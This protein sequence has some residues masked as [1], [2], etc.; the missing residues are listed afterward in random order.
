MLRR[1]GERSGLLYAMPSLAVLATAALVLGPGRERPAVGVRVWGVPAEGSKTAAWRLETIERQFGADQAIT[2]RGM[3]LSLVQGD[4]RLA[5]WSGASGDDGVAEALVRA[6]E[7]LS[8]SVEARIVQGRT[9]LAHGSIAL[10]RVPPPAL[11]RRLA[12][13]TSQGP[14]ALRVDIARGVL[15][16]PFPG[17]I[18]VLALRDGG[19]P[20]QGVA[21]S[22]TATGAEIDAASAKDLRTDAKG[23]ASIRLV[24]TWH[25][26]ELKI[27]A[28]DPRADPPAKSTW[29][30]GLPVHP[31]A[32]WLGLGRPR[33]EVVSPVPR[34]RAYVSALG[35]DGRVFGAVV[36]LAR[37]ETGLF[38]GAFDMAQLAGLG[39]EVLTIAG[40]SQEVG[41]GTASWPLESTQ[42][43][44]SAP[45]VEL[46]LDGVP[47]AERREKARAS[48]ARLAS[49]AVA[50]VAAAFE[51]VL[52]VLY[53]RASQTKLTAHLAALSE[54]PDDTA[55]AERMTAA[56]ASR[57]LTLVALVGVVVL[58]FGAVA[59]FAIVR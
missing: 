30:G 46:M 56:P 25:S 41:S 1:V 10:H 54:S 34:D 16:A 29:E 31:G 2:V 50:L 20:A 40:D 44:V 18:R 59:A 38:E 55:A 51:A 47:F 17:L 42:A 49:V 27:E 58:G 8:G 37:T 11:D 39:A 5:Q 52:L 6:E 43:V 33:V 23:E 19:V 57:A 15:G 24:P 21:V 53:S 12:E 48:N 9:Q 32:L 28:S 14:I 45:R 7:P 3:E 22:A 13:G 4:R 35:K 36:P 26:V